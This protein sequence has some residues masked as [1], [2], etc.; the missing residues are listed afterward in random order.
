[1]QHFRSSQENNIHTTDG[2]NNKHI[3]SNQEPSSRNLDKTAQENTIAPFFENTHG[4]EASMHRSG[5]FDDN[6]K[7]CTVTH[8]RDELGFGEDMNGTDISSLSFR[9]VSTSTPKKPRLAYDGIAKP[10]HIV[11]PISKQAM[12]R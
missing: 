9:L 4:D 2:S 1:M 10:K 8:S 11:E 3:D 7:H 6:V 5:T 12:N